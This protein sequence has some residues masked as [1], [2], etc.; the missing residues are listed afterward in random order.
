[1]PP[2]QRLGRPEP[3][4]GRSSESRGTRIS[5]SMRGPTQTS[6]SANEKGGR[7][8]PTS[9]F[10]NPDELVPDHYGGLGL[11]QVRVDAASAS[12]PV[13]SLGLE[14]RIP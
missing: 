14:L 11:E 5:P 4:H 8:A 9:S 12:R 10:T 7:S 2:N 1:M 3:T 6:T 13:S